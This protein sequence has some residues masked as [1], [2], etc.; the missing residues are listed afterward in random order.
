MMA[1]GVVLLIAVST[2]TAWLLLRET[3]GPGNGGTV[4]PPRARIVLTRVT[5]PPEA[6]DEI[7]SEPETFANFEYDVRNNGDAPIRGLKPALSCGCEVLQ[8]APQALAPGSTARVAFRLRAPPRGRLQRRVEVVADG[9]PWPMTVLDIALRVKFDP[10]ALVT[11]ADTPRVIFVDGENATRPLAFDTAEKK[12]TPRWIT[13]LRVDPPGCVRVVSLHVDDV[14][15]PDP[16]IVGRKYRFEL[17]RAAIGVGCHGAKTVLQTR[18]GAGKS[19]PPSPLQVEVLDRVVILPNPLRLLTAGHH[20]ASG[21]V[22][23]VQRAGA[24]RVEAAQFDRQQIDVRRVPGETARCAAFD[25]AARPGAKAGSQA[26]VLFRV[27]GRESR[28]LVVRFEPEA[29]M[30]RD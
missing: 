6:G 3:G 29:A 20:P 22:I 4:A 17:A 19:P 13:G 7:A 1:F 2:G 16:S 24:D 27:G 21:R 23:V 10:P 8:S 14:P 11:G 30:N 18:L 5:P 26:K 12:G 15:E 9:E 28:E 25:V